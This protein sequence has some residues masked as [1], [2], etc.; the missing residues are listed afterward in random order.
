VIGEAAAVRPRELPRVPL[1]KVR[2]DLAR[3]A[4]EVA[5]FRLQDRGLVGAGDGPQLVSLLRPRLDL[6]RDE[7]SSELRQDLAHR[8]GEGT[9]FRLVQRQHRV[10]H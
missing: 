4:I 1:A 7:V 5:V 3:A 9:P 10:S 2:E 6:S 8:G